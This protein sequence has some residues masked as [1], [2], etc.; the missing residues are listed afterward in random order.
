M[1]WAIHELHPDKM[2]WNESV[3]NRLVG[4]RR[5]ENMIFGGAHPSE[6]FSS[7]EEELAEF[8]EMRGKYLLY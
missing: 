6:I 3:M 1:V 5:L 2:E 7:W 4:T 8:K